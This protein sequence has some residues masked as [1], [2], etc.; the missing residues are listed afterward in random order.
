MEFLQIQKD[1]K[2]KNANQRKLSERIKEEMKTTKWKK[3]MEI[4][5]N[6]TSYLKKRIILK[7][8]WKKFWR[9][10][11]NLKERETLY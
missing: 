10:S 1:K 11:K 6:E 4:R 8:K 9:K 3:E 2:K 5:K 7:K